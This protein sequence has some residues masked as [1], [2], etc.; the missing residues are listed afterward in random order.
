[1][2]E[3]HALEGSNLQNQ[4]NSLVGDFSYRKVQN[5]LLKTEGENPV[6]KREMG[7]II[8]TMIL[9]WSHPTGIGIS[10]FLLYNCWTN[11]DQILFSQL[12]RAC[13]VQLSIK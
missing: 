3:K 1:M 4:E 10:R 5:A 2:W 7:L 6:I 13:G 12:E 9:L 11:L 8:L